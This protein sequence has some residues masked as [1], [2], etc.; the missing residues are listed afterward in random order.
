MSFEG[1]LG[2]YFKYKPKAPLCTHSNGPVLDFASVNF[3][4]CLK[5]DAEEFLS[6]FVFVMVNIFKDHYS[7]I[8]FGM[9]LLFDLADCTVYVTLG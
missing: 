2:S 3:E 7:N 1:H 6:W 8:S 5:Y 4:E 9:R